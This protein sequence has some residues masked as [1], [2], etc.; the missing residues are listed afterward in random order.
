MRH[1][2]KWRILAILKIDGH[3]LSV[4]PRKQRTFFVLAAKFMI[5][6]RSARGRSTSL[7][8]LD[9]SGEPGEFSIEAPLRILVSLELCFP[10]LGGTQ[11]GGSA[12][13]CVIYGRVTKESR[14]L[15]RGL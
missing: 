4:P 6:W 1:G 3:Q 13:A 7:A 15:R 12:R 14:G 10:W 5:L 11:D 8:S 9:T 2:Q